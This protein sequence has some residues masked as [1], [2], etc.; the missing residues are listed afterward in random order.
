MRVNQYGVEG[1]R[2][3]RRNPGF[4]TDA[5]N[6][7]L[8]VGAG[9]STIEANDHVR[10]DGRRARSNAQASVDR[11]SSEPGVTTKQASSLNTILVHSH[12]FVHAVMAMESR[13]YRNPRDA[14]PSWLPLFAVSVD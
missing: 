2:L 14:S 7:R 5:V 4:A 10:L 8:S 11:I 3:L 1:R 6:R 13:L 12:T 9:A